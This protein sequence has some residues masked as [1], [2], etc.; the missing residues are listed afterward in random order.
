MKSTHCTWITGGGSGIG[1]ALAQQLAEQGRVIVITGRDPQ[2]LS[3]A[4]QTINARLEF[5]RAHY[6]VL[7]VT[8]AQA[9]AECINEI[10]KNQGLIELAVLNA[11]DHFANGL[12]D[13]SVVPF[14][15]LFE[16]NVFGVLNC[17]EALLPRFKARNA[18]HIAVTASVAGYQGLPLAS[19]YGASKA[20]II[21]A[22]EA[23]YFELRLTQIKLQIINP[24]FV[25]TPLTDK[26]T[27]E[28][29]FLVEPEDAAKAIIKG[30]TSHR[31]E[32]AFPTPF[33]L[34]LKTLRY[35]PYRWYFALVGRMT[36]FSSSGSEK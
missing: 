3:K 19:A 1:F 25:K 23:L 10:E 30:L 22:C 24:G 5:P 8:N 12:D 34:I 18:G 7:D 2:R 16:V 15:Q 36:G 32:I 11:G 17:V 20:A 21:H 31:F 9:V 6:Q 29:P 4:C 26:N 14:R 35:L 33:V 28:M 27:F 13:F